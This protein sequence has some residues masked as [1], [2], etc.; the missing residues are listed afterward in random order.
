MKKFDLVKEYLGYSN[1]KDVTNLDSRYLVPPSQNVIINDGEKVASRPGYSLYGAAST[2]LFPIVSSYEWKTAIGYE[3]A[4]RSENGTL[5]CYYG[6]SWVDI[7]TGFSAIDFQFTTVWDSTELLVLMLFVN[8]DS[9]MRMWSGGITTFASATANTITK[10]GSTSWAAEGFLKSGTRQVNI[11]G[12]TYTYT[13]GESTTTLTGVTPDPTAGSH[14][15]GSVITQTV[16]TTAN[17][18]ASGLNNDIISTLKNQVYVGDLKRRDV[19]VSKNTSYTDFTFTAPIRLPGEGAI[20][21]LDANVV[22]FAPQ[23]EDM[24]IGVDDGWFKTNFTLA[25]DL[26]AESLRVERLKT[27]PQQGPQSQSSICKVKN[28]V[29]F[30]CKD[31]SIDSLGRVTNLVTPDS[32]PLS[33]IIKNEIDGYSFVSDPHLVYNQNMLHALFPS[34][35]KMLIYDFDR[36]YWMP[37]QLMSLNRLAIIGTSL[38][39]HS[40]SVTESYRILNPSVYSDNGNSIDAKAA[41]SYRNY[42]YRAWKKKF[43]EWYTEVYMSANTNLNLQINYEFG[44]YGGIVTKIIR[45][46]ETRFKFFISLLN[47]LGKWALGKNPIGS[48]SAEQ[49]ALPK[50][51][52]IDTVD[53]KDFYE[54]QAIYSSNGVDQRWEL[55]AFGGNVR[56]SE[57]DNSDIKD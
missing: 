1:K 10:Q 5:Q 48:T 52:K 54:A 53:D 4:L 51:R 43:D 13:G 35:G 50:Y 46:T 45:G 30:V 49:I 26:S 32:R 40:S 44:G 3:R 8:G 23:E 11:N 55:L 56:L 17:T 25:A 20:L 24:Y 27:S 38:Y 29:V 47:S 19:W 42:G 34:E 28:S 33:D 6:T 12:T 7:A 16:R 18:P 57:N 37:P 41:F 15:V 36:K 31:K 9:N 22:G 14:A 2:D 39:G 21:T